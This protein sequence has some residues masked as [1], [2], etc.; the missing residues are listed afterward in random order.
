MQVEAL[1]VFCDVA[2]LRSFS[3]AAAVNGISQPT[4]TRLIRQLEERLGG[5]LVDRTK[6]PPHLTD[7]GRDYHAGV[8]RLLEQFIELEASL[9]R[10]YAGLSLTV[11]VAAIYSVGL[12]D[13]GKYVERFSQAFPHARVRIDYV[14]PKQVYEHVRDGSAD[15]GLISY[16]ARTRE[17]KVL[18]WREEVMV[19]ACTPSH[20]LAQLRSVSPA[21]LSGQRFVA[22][23]RGLVI[24]QRIDRYLH[25]NGVQVDI[26]HEF[27]N[28]ETIKK[29]IEAGAGVGILPEPMLRQEVQAGTL[30]SVKLE[31]EP[32]IRPLGI[33][34]RRG[35][36]LSHAAR[37]FIDLLRGQKLRPRQ[38]KHRQVRLSIE[39]LRG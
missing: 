1:K 28:I 14:H 36:E 21:R 38:E 6:R 30:R 34:H 37:G 39:R 10:E 31:G 19:L 12:S 25:D 18:P 32:L 7:L 16:P 17:F 5:L 22:F 23:E 3:R 13:M 4:V 20:P 33:I 15:L 24:R 2:E 27:D 35:S 26:V 11:R 29:G 9:R 8:K